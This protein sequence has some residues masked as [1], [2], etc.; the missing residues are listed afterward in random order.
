MRGVWSGYVGR[1]A[2]LLLRLGMQ[3]QVGSLCLLVRLELPSI[4]HLRFQVIISVF[5][6]VSPFFEYRQ[7]WCLGDWV[8][9]DN[10]ILVLS[11]KSKERGDAS[12]G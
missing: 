6:L 3:G 5:K 12:G 1:G 2:T 10:P 9:F 4:N 7:Y 11:M 8:L